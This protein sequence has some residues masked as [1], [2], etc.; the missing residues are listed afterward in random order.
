MT[1][2]HSSRTSASRLVV[3]SCGMTGKAH[4]DRLALPMKLPAPA[5]KVNGRLDALIANAL[6]SGLA[7]GAMVRIV[8][9]TNAGLHPGGIVMGPIIRFA[10]CALLLGGATTLR[11]G[12]DL[13]ERLAVIN[14]AVPAKDKNELGALAISPDGKTL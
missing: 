9:R 12:D 2:W 14:V 5:P 11:A 4:P 13:P 6:F 7:V 8:D 1:F 3:N 10:G